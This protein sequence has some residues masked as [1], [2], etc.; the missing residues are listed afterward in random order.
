M[1]RQRLSRG[2]G[3]CCLCREGTSETGDHLALE[4]TGSRGAVGWDGARWLE[5]E[6]KSKWAY[7]FK[8]G[9]KVWVGDRAEDFFA[10]LDRE[11]CRVG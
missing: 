8:E 11:L 5:M 6:D 9:G 2:V 7:E 4:C 1:W 3:L 10:W